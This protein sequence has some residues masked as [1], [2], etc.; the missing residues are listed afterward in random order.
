MQ[1]V[2]ALLGEMWELIPA[3]STHVDFR[4]KC[5]Q[6]LSR[7]AALVYSTIE[8][9]H[10]RFPINVF[11]MVRN[12]DLAPEIAA[13]AHKHPCLLDK[14]TEQLLKE[15]PTLQD[16]QHCIC[17]GKA[18]VTEETFAHEVADE[19]TRCHRAQCGLLSGR[20]QYP[21]AK[22]N[23]HPR[24]VE[25]RVPH[26]RIRVISMKAEAM[27]ELSLRRNDKRCGGLW[28]AW[29]RYITHGSTGVP[30][31]KALAVSFKS[32]IRDND[33]VL[34]KV[35]RMGV[36][37]RNVG[38]SS[39]AKRIS[40][41][42]LTNKQ[43][44]RH[45]TRDKRSTFWEASR[46]MPALKK[47]KFL[48]SDHNT[49]GVADCLAVARRVVYLEGVRK[50]EQEAEQRKQ[51]Q[52]WRDT[53]G[54]QQTQD[55]FQLLPELKSIIPSLEAMPT[56]HGRSYQFSASGAA[57]C[58]AAL[59]TAS[60]TRSNLPNSLWKEWQQ[61]HETINEVSCQPLQGEHE[62][63]SDCRKSGYCHCKPAGRIVFGLRQ[64]LHRKLKEVFPGKDGRDKLASAD[65]IFSLNKKEN[66][67]QD[68]TSDEDSFWYHVS[69]VSFSPY[70]PVFHLL[71]Q[72]S[73]HGE[74]RQ[75][76]PRY[77]L[78]VAKMPLNQT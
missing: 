28:R 16:A 15:F 68:H 7:Q 51:M 17:R 45:S 1:S 39:S 75:T 3:Q 65:I 19:H 61:L 20:Q 62:K 66:C 31:L 9:E 30:D 57:T 67:T 38:M 41:F 63:I 46:T 64:R 77:V 33:P 44:R 71:K 50:R 59:A 18:C 8:L 60:A 14:W 37:A 70:E 36:A 35:Q 25:N 78:Q 42:G 26:P 40:N 47:A 53:Y 74:G 22:I 48:A 54:K 12:K 6:L 4:R 23:P 10:K 29:V 49:S 76:P 58:T 34:Q 13:E 56:S 73:G 52:Q 32:A 69:Y 11:R 2:T 72:L 24:T 27:G 5:F 55:F 43:L 21:H